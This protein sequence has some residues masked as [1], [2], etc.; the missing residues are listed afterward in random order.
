ME[1]IEMM[2]LET[3][4]QNVQTNFSSF[5]FFVFSFHKNRK[6]EKWKEKTITNMPLITALFLVDIPFPHLP[7]YSIFNFIFL[8]SLINN[9]RH[10]L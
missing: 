3:D 6:T 7:A 9:S 1:L 4:N 2:I 5:L 8:H 10:A